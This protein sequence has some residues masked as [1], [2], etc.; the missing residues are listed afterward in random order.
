MANTKAEIIDNAVQKMANDV[1]SKVRDEGYIMRSDLTDIFRETYSKLREDCSEEELSGLD[2]LFVLNNAKISSLP[3][4][5][6]AKDYSNQAT[7]TVH[8]PS[9]DVTQTIYVKGFA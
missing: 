5:H 2:C 8:F 4:L 6:I 7:L 1:A 9:G 3:K